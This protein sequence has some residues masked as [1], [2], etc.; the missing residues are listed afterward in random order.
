MPTRNASNDDRYR[1][2]ELPASLEHSER[3]AVIE[4]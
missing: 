1:S 2:K 4:R 3:D